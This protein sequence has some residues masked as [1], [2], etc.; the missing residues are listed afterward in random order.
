M[1]ITIDELK[2]IKMKWFSIIGYIVLGLQVSFPSWCE[3]YHVA[4]N[5]SDKQ[6]GT[7]GTP[8]LTI[9]RAAE[10]AQPGD[11]ITIHEG[12]YRECIIP[13]RGGNSDKE[14]IIYQAAEG[15]S[16]VVSGAE[17]ATGWK[18]VKNNTWTLTLPNTYF[19]EINPFDEQIYGSWYRGKG[20]PNHTGMVF[21][22]DQ[23]IRECFSLQDVMQPLEGQP[24][25][26]AEADGNG[27]KVLMNLEWI[28]PSGGELMNSMQAS[29]KGGDQAV[30]IA[31]V[32]RWPFGYLKDGS[33]MYFDQLDFGT[34]SDSLYLQV[35]TL[36]KGG[37][38]EV[39]LDKPDGELLGTA[40]IT[41]TGDWEQFS[42]FALKLNRMIQGKHDVC[43]R[44]KAPALK[45]NGQTT[46]WAQF[47]E[48]MDPN[49]EKVEI[50]KRSQV[51]YP[52]KTGIDY[53]TIR[54]LILEKAATNWAPPSAE[55]PG[56]I[57]TRWGKGWIIENN[58][59][60]YSRCSGIALGRPTYG[61]AHHYQ[62]MPP[63]IYAE[64][65]SGQTEE[66]LAD[67]F[68]NASWD[69]DATGHHI[70]RNNHIYGC[71]QTGIVGCSGGAFSLIEGNEIHDICVDETFEGDEMAGIKLHFANDAVLKNNHIYR[72]IRGLWLDWGAQGV[73][74]V[75]NLFHDN[76][77]E[78]IFAEVCHGPLLIAN[79]ILL[80]DHSLSVSQGI[81]GVHNLIKGKVT[82]GVDRC[83][84]G[85]LS[86]Y[87]EPHGTVSLG[88][89][90]NPGG[91][92]QWYNNLLTTRKNLGEW[93]EPG[94]PIEEEGNS[95]ALKNV[96]LEEK[97][98]GWYLSLTV[99]PDSLQV[100]PTRFITTSVLRN[101]ITSK[102][103]FT[104]PDGSAIKIDRD[105][106]GAKRNRKRPCPG[107]FEIQK[108]N[109]KTCLVW[110]K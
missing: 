89:A 65:N 63:R 85:R 104:N 22:N 50:T 1:N 36:A 45:Q 83:A 72:T 107:A 7:K 88:K 71:G 2:G 41:N 23:R 44:L 79:N 48:G 5:G 101:T 43:L 74:V 15:E 77:L 9:T 47:P 14:R 19:E 110:E 34:A 90:P 86:Y 49:Q 59:I 6:S 64:E 27:G 106:T 11:I 33:E 13:P 8:F 28:K 62:K 46:I 60:R 3:E 12:V 78:D 93:D 69:K 20:R 42:V 102:Q 76:K 30:C 16:V 38:V 68:E 67:Y 100:V 26:Y 75:D 51:F 108:G 109:L 99:E 37:M 55:Q 31:V 94:L 98:D 10:V 80:S 32:N 87:Y 81:A 54:G 97:E 52:D 39:Y 84:G 25:F 17:L 91:D 40:M 24:Y 57:G 56:L 53:L 105:Y 61:H 21:L 95:F 4:K 96:R 58:T 103:A 70:I 18:H 29:V 82:G 35:A 92:C 73:Q 66:Q